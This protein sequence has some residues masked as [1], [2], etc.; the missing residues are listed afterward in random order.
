MSN[1]WKSFVVTPHYV[2]DLNGREYSFL[3]PPS[4]KTELL[5]W[6]ALETSSGLEIQTL[7]DALEAFD[8][9]SQTISVILNLPPSQKVDELFETESIESIFTSIWQTIVGEGTPNDLIKDLPKSLD[10]K[11]EPFNFAQA[12]AMFA[13]ECGWTPDQVLSLPKIQVVHLA[14]AISEYVGHRM[15][16]QA[17]IH[18][19]PMDAEGTS[20]GTSPTAQIDI[21]SQIEQ[22]RKKGLAIEER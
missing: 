6:E 9:I 17:A 10:S 11:A 2:T 21:E 15:K 13:C 8:L 20:S 4:W 1:D 14:S 5:I 18:G 3:L 19:V 7:D 12:L 22:F 16:F